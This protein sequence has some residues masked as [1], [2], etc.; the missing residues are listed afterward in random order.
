MNHFLLFSE[1]CIYSPKKL[2]R[3]G[4]ILPGFLP[5]RTFKQA[6]MIVLISLFYIFE[7][8]PTAIPEEPFNN[9]VGTIG[10]K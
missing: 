7:A 8:N 1:S 4:L 10:K 2:F 5:E 3:C 9:T 6:S